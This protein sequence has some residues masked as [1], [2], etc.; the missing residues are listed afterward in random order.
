MPTENTE[1][2][3][4]TI[5]PDTPD[6]VLSYDKLR[7]NDVVFD[8]NGNSYS[9]RDM[10]LVP[11]DTPRRKEEPLFLF[12]RNEDGQERWIPR[13]SYEKTV[14]AVR[15]PDPRQ[16]KAR[17]PI[18]IKARP[19]TESPVKARPVKERPVS[20]HASARACTDPPKTPSIEDD[21]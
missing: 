16:T 18:R 2:P 20:A 14:I 5:L 1:P 6:S 13:Y 19:E 12:R 15:R 7:V 21:F 3:A 8:R 11:S 4:E 10:K 17:S 9:V